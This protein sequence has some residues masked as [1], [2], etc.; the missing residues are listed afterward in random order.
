LQEFRSCRIKAGAVCNSGRR[1]GITFNGHQSREKDVT[2][3]AGQRTS[4][5][6]SAGAGCVPNP[7]H[8]SA[9]DLSV[10]SALV[11]MPAWCEC[12]GILAIPA[13]ST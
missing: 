1:S 3:D 2:L 6:E 10:L 11:S 12:S 7:G 4:F 8:P 5:V 13:V 9:S